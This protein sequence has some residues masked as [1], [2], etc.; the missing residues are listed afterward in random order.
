MRCLRPPT[1]LSAWGKLIHK[2]CEEAQIWTGWYEGIDEW[3]QHEIGGR[4]IRRNTT[5][6]TEKQIRDW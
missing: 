5:K 4:C 6:E 1:G 2:L 3:G